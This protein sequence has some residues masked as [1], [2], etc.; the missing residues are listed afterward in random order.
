M[1]FSEFDLIRNVFAPLCFD[2]R[3]LGLLDDGAVILPKEGSETIISTDTLVEGVH[4]LAYEKPEIIARR[5][6]RVNLSDMASMAAKPNGYFLNLTLS[7]EIDDDWITAF[8]EGLRLRSWRD[9]HA[10]RRC[11]W[12]C[13]RGAVLRAER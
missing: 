10:A 1:R 11:R 7:S 3:A 9:G 8:A 12:R 6:L 4:F 5:L 2:D 13:A